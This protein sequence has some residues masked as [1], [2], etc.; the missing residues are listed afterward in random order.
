MHFY[1]KSFCLEEGV[2]GS[3]LTNVLLSY[4]EIKM[5]VMAAFFL[6]IFFFLIF[7][8]KKTYRASGMVYS[9]K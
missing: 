6:L 1:C 9:N 2:G 4:F 7:K 3:D 5:V 8:S